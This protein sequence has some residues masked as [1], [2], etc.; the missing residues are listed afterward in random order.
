MEAPIQQ[1]ARVGRQGEPSAEPWAARSRASLGSEVA[2][3]EL[4]F[5]NVAARAFT[6]S[7]SSSQTSPVTYEPTERANQPSPIE[8]A[9]RPRASARARAPAVKQRSVEA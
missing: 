3:I 5:V 2:R 7:A 4:T 1:K 6:Q 9:H 8:G